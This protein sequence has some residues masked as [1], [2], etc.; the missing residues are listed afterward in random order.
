MNKV[1][2]IMEA[3]KASDFFKR[4]EKLNRKLSKS[5]LNKVEYTLSEPYW[6]E[7][8]INPYERHYEDADETTQC[9]VYNIRVI[10]VEVIFNELFIKGYEMV[11]KIDHKERII[12]HCGNKEDNLNL[13]SY[14]DNPRCD[15]CQT[16]AIRNKTYILR[17]DNKFYQVG[18]SCLKEYL[19]I[20]KVD[21]IEQY[22]NIYAYFKSFKV[23]ADTL[24]DFVISEVSLDKAINFA[25][26]FIKRF[27]YDKIQIKTSFWTYI[28]NPK[29]LDNKGFE[30]V[31]YFVENTLKPQPE[32]ISEIKSY[33]QG[34]EVYNDFIS[35][36]KNIF[37]NGYITD[38][39]SG[40]LFG[41]IAN[42]LRKKAENEDKSKSDWI[43]KIGDKITV[44]AIYKGCNVYTSYYGR[45][46]T[47]N[48][49]YKFVSGSNSISW[50]TTK[51]V[52]FKEGQEYLIESTIKDHKE[53]KGEKITYI[54]NVKIIDNQNIEKQDVDKVAQALNKLDEYIKT[55]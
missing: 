1:Y 26:C 27:G 39:S 5:G 44:K 7:F 8:I 35:N 33:V 43:G 17:K 46:A 16:K 48:N 2:F 9:K 22:F 45:T 24:K 19:D 34:L 37:D 18:S 11:A 14:L 12:D 42:Y 49:I 50:F 28:Q 51:N 4:V 13:S 6:K 55:I 47:Y 36:I 15:H 54:K 52:D 29:N 3:N 40:Y 31:K 21:N 32:F 38:K 20:A 30:D 23:E 41:F 10:N 25:Y 53:Y